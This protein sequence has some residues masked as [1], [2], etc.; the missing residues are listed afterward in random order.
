VTLGSLFK[1][2]NCSTFYCMY[3]L[4]IMFVL[5]P[6]SNEMISLVHILN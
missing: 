6:C 5:V 4:Y 1:V 3:Y 2:L